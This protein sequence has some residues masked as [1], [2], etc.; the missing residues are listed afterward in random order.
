MM[1]DFYINLERQLMKEI[2]ETK[3]FSFKKLV[4]IAE[5]SQILA[6]MKY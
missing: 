5:L 2:E 3:G 6:S 1:R 4:K